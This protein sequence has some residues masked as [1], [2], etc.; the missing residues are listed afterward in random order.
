MPFVLPDPDL[1]SLN[2]MGGN[3]TGECDWRVGS[4]MVFGSRRDETIFIW[5]YHSMIQATID[6]GGKPG[7]FCFQ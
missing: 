3:V 1:P 4:E 6:S 2:V 7:C 5:L